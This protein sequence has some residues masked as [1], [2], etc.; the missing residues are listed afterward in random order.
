MQR[1]G[2]GPICIKVLLATI[3][4]NAAPF[5]VSFSRLFSAG[6]VAVPLGYT[7]YAAGGRLTT[8]IDARD[9]VANHYRARAG[10]ASSSIRSRGGSSLTRRSGGPSLPQC[11]AGDGL[12]RG[13]PHQRRDQP[14]AE[15]GRRF[16]R[17][18][19]QKV[20]HLLIS[21]SGAQLWVPCPRER[22]D[23]GGIAAY[24]STSCLPAA[25]RRTRLGRAVR[26]HR[27]APPV[28]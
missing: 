11:R 5:F 26:D 28:R 8:C 12:L 14:T 10:P 27:L 16:L 17:L 2:G 6:M 22:G 24:R 25:W 19:A 18:D 1:G 9:L 3:S 13:Y 23:E 15:S 4:C 21:I 20:V 7:T